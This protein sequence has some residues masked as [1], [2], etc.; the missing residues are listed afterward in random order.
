[1]HIIATDGKPR[2]AGLLVQYVMT[3]KSEVPDVAASHPMAYITK[4]SW[5]A[6]GST[7]PH[8]AAEDGA[9]S[10][11]VS[12]LTQPNP[13]HLALLP[14]NSL[15]PSWVTPSGLWSTCLFGQDFPK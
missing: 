12:S 5:P 10:W 9:A 7:L 4:C 13:D 11:H 15:E 1:M 3:S 14:W 6:P 8:S 2:V